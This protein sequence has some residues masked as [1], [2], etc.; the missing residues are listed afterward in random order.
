MAEH[1]ERMPQ[2]G[3]FSSGRTSEAELLALVEAA[4]S[5]P[6]PNCDYRQTI[7]GLKLLPQHQSLPWWS[8]EARY[9]HIAR[10]I[11]DSGVQE[12]KY[13]SSV[14]LHSALVTAESLEAGSCLIC[15][16]LVDKF[17]AFSMTP[18]AEINVDKPL[19]AY[20]LDSLVGIEIRNWINNEIDV[21]LSIMELMTGDSLMQLSKTIAERSPTLT[22]YH[23]KEEQ[24]GDDR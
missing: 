8:T 22:Q 2:V 1:Q 23:M 3:V 10:N 15:D 20:G 21:N 17:A 4:I 6:N 5:H 12:P 19:S 13:V 18:Y 7:T 24:N 9:A 14:S 16:A 11:I